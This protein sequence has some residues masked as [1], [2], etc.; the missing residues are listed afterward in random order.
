MSTPPN[1]SQDE[2]STSDWFWTLLI[3]SIPVLNLIMAIYWALSSR[4]K[5][6]KRNF[7]LAS[8]LWVFVVFVLALI[9]AFFQYAVKS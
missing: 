1:R 6:S 8:F 5:P 7:F 3:L 9:A 2:V 4:T